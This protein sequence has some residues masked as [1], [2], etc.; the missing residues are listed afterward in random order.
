[1]Q[2]MGVDVHKALFDLQ[3]HGAATPL[4]FGHS[5]PVSFVIVTQFPQEIYHKI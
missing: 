4:S 3:A 5:N 1:M 2:N